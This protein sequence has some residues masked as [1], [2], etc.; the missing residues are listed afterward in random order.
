MSK[1]ERDEFYLRTIRVSAHYMSFFKRFICAL[2]RG[3]MIQ[4][5]QP[6][7]TQAY[8]ILP[9]Q[10]ILTIAIQNGLVTLD[11]EDPLHL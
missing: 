1:H 9:K 7:I 2:R 4:K 5:P 6:S 8:P 3:G 10:Q 11:R